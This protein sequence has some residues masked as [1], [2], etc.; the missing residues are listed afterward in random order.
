[1]TQTRALDGFE[2]PGLP[3]RILRL[4]HEPQRVYAAVAARGG[5]WTDW[6][7]PTALVAG[8]W[9]A[10]NLAV[11]S[12]VAPDAPSEM[13]GWDSLG[14]E[15]REQAR[16]GLLQWRTHGWFSLPAIS[17]FSS[18]AFTGLV[19]TGVA[20]WV[21][22]AEASLLQML[23]VKAYASLVAIPQWILLTPLVRAGGGATPASFSPAALLPAEAAATT[24]GLFLAGLNLFDAWQAWVIGIG[25]AVLTG[26]PRRRSVAAVLVL[27]VA[28]LALAALTAAV[29][30]SAAPG[31]A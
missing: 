3:E 7:V 15:D 28:W 5:G 21:L 31:R 4:F 14:E 17:A 23:M 9:A 22:R 24:L 10:H 16:Q 8:I 20:R 6:V 2:A 25:L 1:M 30:P 19:L 18:L 27:W 26:A 12:V 29:V 13:P 11:L